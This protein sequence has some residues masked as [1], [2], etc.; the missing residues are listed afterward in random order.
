MRN[1]EVCRKL[2]YDDRGAAHEVCYYITVEDLTGEDGEVVCENYGLGASSQD[3][4]E[5]VV[6]GITPFRESIERLAAAVVCGDV[7]PAGLRDA[8]EQWISL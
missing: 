1:T 8:V 4:G 7:T 5:S 6:R 3:W 2:I